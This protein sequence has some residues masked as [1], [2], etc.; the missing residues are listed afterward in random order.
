MSGYLAAKHRRDGT[1]YD[2]ALVLVR[3]AKPLLALYHGGEAG[4]RY[5]QDA[6]IRAVL[7]KIARCDV[8]NEPQKPL[9]SLAT[10]AGKI[11]IAVK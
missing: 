3:T 11:F 2:E 4:R 7:E 8:R 9:L 1:S 6:A 5:Y 10:G